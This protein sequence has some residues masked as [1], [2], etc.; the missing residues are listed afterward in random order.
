MK[1]ITL[2]IAVALGV[3]GCKNIDDASPSTRGTFI[4]AY[5][6]P[7]SYEAKAI[8]KTAEGYVVVGTM[9]SA[10]GTL[11]DTQTVVF[12]TDHSGNRI[13]DVVYFEN[14]IGNGVKPFTNTSFSGYI[15]VGD[16]IKINPTASQGGNIEISTMQL[17]FIDENLN[18]VGSYAVNDPSTDPQRVLTDYSGNAVTVT[19]DGRVMVL[20]SYVA[21]G[22]PKKPFVLSLLNN[23]ELEWTNYYN[24]IN[25]DNINGKSIHYSGGNIIWASSI[26]SESGNFSDSYI[27]IPFVK[28]TLSFKNYDALGQEKDHAFFAND[29][30]PA[31]AAGFGF[32]V[33]GTFGNRDGSQKNVFFTTVNTEGDIVKTDT[34]FIDAVSGV[35]RSDASQIEDTG[36]ALAHTSDGGFIIGGTI[37]TIAGDGGMGNGGRDI[38]LIKIGPFRTIEWI[39]TIGGS[40][41][42]TVSAVREADDGGL[43]IFGTNNIGNYSSIFLIKTNAK[44][45]L[46]K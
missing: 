44:G 25:L 15:I 5:E 33:V 28:E 30:T 35:T 10:N 27:T 1:K 38:L 18:E 16:R 11:E 22:Q 19:S 42:E 26:L 46:I 20:G 31:R 21:D 41:D 17:L 39:K 40:G 3:W 32:G 36:D 23:L 2:A 43:V 13:G 6:G 4:K 24:V 34:L 8:E 9:R 12:R 14:L 29:I 45:E 37:T 7:E